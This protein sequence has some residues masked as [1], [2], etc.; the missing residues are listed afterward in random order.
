MLKLLNAQQCADALSIGIATWW[1]WVAEGRTPPKH[2]ISP[3]RVA[4]RSDDIEDLINRIA[5][6]EVSQ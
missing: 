3:K 6:R 1:R 4:W 5:P 2:M